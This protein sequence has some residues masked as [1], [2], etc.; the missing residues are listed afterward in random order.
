MSDL[1]WLFAIFA[2]C[3]WFWQQRKQNERAQELIEQRCQQ[4]ELQLVSVARDNIC[5]K[6]GEH[7]L[8][9]TFVFEFSSDSENCYQ[10]YLRLSGQHKYHFDIPP[11]RMI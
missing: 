7:F 1:F 10:G 6:L 5:F 2:I 9:Q 8:E 3:I 4:L 11:Y